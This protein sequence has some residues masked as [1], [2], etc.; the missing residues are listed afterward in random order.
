MVMCV[1]A[2]PTVGPEGWGWGVGG[3]SFSYGTIGILVE[4]SLNP[5][6]TT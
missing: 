1:A 5:S 4:L 3:S 6:S 2:E